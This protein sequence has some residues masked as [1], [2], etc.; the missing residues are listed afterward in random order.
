MKNPALFLILLWIKDGS[1]DLLQTE[2][3]ASIRHVLDALH[4]SWQICDI[5]NSTLMTFTWAT[6]DITLS[7]VGQLNLPQLPARGG[8]ECTAVNCHTQMVQ[9]GTMIM[10]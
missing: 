1:P 5:L 4:N 2:D 7:R 8:G 9:I 10:K 6:K 3:G